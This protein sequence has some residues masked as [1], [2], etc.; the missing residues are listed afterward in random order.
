[1]AGH[2]HLTRSPHTGCNTTRTTPSCRLETPAWSSLPALVPM[3]TAHSQ[4]CAIHRR[5]PNLVTSSVVKLRRLTSSVTYCRYWTPRHAW[6]VVRGVSPQPSSQS[7]PTH[8]LQPSAASPS[9]AGQA[10]TNNDDVIVSFLHPLRCSTACCTRPRRS[11]LAARTRTRTRTPN[12]NL[13]SLYL[14]TT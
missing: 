13:D 9:A 4:F 2:R 11:T 8:P 5:P 1:M 3:R 10:H 7:T 12:H 14:T 6:C